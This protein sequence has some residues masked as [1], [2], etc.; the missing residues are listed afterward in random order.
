MK[1]GRLTG[2]WGGTLE[3]SRWSPCRI[4]LRGPSALL[5]EGPAGIGKTTRG[6][7][8]SRRWASGSPRYRPA[9]PMGLRRAAAARPTEDLVAAG[10]NRVPT[11]ITRPRRRASC[12]GTGGRIG[13]T[14][15]P[16]GRSAPRPRALRAGPAG[17]RG[18]RWYPNH[19]HEHLAWVGIR[20]G[21]LALAAE[22][23]S[24]SR[25]WT[26]RTTCPAIRAE[27]LSTFAMV[28]VL[29]GRPAQ[30]LMTEAAAGGPG[31]AGGPGVR[32]RSSPRPGP[33]SRT[34]RCCG[35]ASWTPRGRC[36]T[37]SWPNTSRWDG[38]EG[39]APDL[40]GRGGMPA[41]GKL[42]CRRQARPGGLRDRRRVWMGVGTGSHAVP[43]GAG[44]GTQ[45]RRGHGSVG[46]RAA[47]DS[48]WWNEDM[49]DASCNRTVLGFELSLSNPG[50]AMERLGPVLAFLD[51]MGSPEPGVIPC[52]P[53]A[54]EASASLGE[55]GRGRG[56]RRSSGCGTTLDRPWAIATAGRGRGLLTSTRGDLSAARSALEQAM[57]EHRRVPQPFELARTLLVKGEE[58]RASRNEPPAPPWSRRW[59]FQA[60]ARR[61]WRRGRRTTSPA[62][63]PRCRRPASSPPSNGSPS[64]SGR[65]EEPRGRCPVHLR[66]DRRG[67]PVTDLP[68]ARGSFAHGAHPP[69]RR[70]P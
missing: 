29:L 39:R 32:R 58:R 17:G 52:V 56:T 57:A 15:R 68:Q 11:G 3:S 31:D 67:E 61:S 4:G 16:W 19:G 48:P 65:E 5:L 45:G 1:G 54:V 69:D 21:D 33:A 51:E 22:R 59:S 53:D 6:R 34:L 9:P 62:S 37:R 23:A 28:E 27:S 10:S 38:G 18:G 63:A 55:A 7:C 30:D 13:F 40:P 25:Q 20:R 49:L 46:R 41:V 44:G 70:H 66:K 2:S 35:R 50:A 24:A 8:R 12:S 64:W 42:G 14:T 26:R 43:Q 36:S 47:S 60:P